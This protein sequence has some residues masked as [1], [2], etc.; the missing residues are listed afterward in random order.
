MN[1]IDP[2]RP[3]SLDDLVGP[4]SS[5]PAFDDY[6]PAS[7]YRPYRWEMDWIDT[8]PPV[9][10]PPLPPVPEPP[11]LPTYEDGLMTQELFDKLMRD[12]R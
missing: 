3:S 2:L 5:R 10:P 7:L 1:P 4:I 6:G 12:L 8:P 11:R 9:A